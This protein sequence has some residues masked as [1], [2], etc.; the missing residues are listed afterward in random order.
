MDF[1][2]NLTNLERF[3]NGTVEVSELERIRKREKA[4]LLVGYFFRVFEF[5]DGRAK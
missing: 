3:G 5:Y 4:F 2:S 1:E